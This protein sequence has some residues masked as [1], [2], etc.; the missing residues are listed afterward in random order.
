MG[1][2]GARCVYNLHKINLF[3]AKIMIPPH[4]DFQLANGKQIR[5]LCQCLL[6]VEICVLKPT[7]SLSTTVW[8]GDH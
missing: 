7:F 1:K 6:K 8:V 4:P 3:Y 2:L 5:I